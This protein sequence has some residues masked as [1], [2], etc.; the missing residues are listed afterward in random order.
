MQEYFREES[1]ASSRGDARESSNDYVEQDGKR[2]VLAG[3]RTE[4]VN[5]RQIKLEV[6]GRSVA[7]FYHEGQFYALDHHCYRK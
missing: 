4:L 1:Y 5:R 2:F 6:N 7:L 3:D